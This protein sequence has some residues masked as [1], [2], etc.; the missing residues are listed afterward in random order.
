MSSFV[1]IPRNFLPRL[2]D[3]WS[4]SL[5]LICSYNKGKV[6]LILSKLAA[7]QTANLNTKLSS[8]LRGIYTCDFLRFRRKKRKKQSAKGYTC[9]GSLG[10]YPINCCSGQGTKVSTALGT[11]A[12]IYNGATTLSIITFSK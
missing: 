8:L 7:A 5:S 4:L 12:C 1:T 10:R 3:F 11:V 2:S 9:L 6:V